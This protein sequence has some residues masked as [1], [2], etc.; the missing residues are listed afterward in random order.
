MG[1]KQ[2]PLWMSKDKE[3][4]FGDMGEDLVS[5]N[6]FS[7]EYVVGLMLERAEI[8]SLVYALAEYCGLPLF[9]RGGEN[10]SFNDNLSS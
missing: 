7:E 3:L 9:G 4:R 10:G 6:L 1:G 5:V 8:E 2:M